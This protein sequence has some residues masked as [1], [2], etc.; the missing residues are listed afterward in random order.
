M[1]PQEKIDAI[2]AYYAENFSRKDPTII[3][4]Y[5]PN[6]QFEIYTDMKGLV[7]GGG[8]KNITA[9]Q[10]ALEI[11]GFVKIEE[12]S[13]LQTLDIQKI[14]TIRQATRLHSAY[15]NKSADDEDRGFLFQTKDR[16]LLLP[17]S[18]MD[19]IGT[20]LGD[21]TKES[22]SLLQ[23]VKEKYYY[24]PNNTQKINN[25]IASIEKRID[26]AVSEVTEEAIFLNQQDFIY[27]KVYSKTAEFNERFNPDELAKIKK[28]EVEIQQDLRENR[29]YPYK[30]KEFDAQGAF[31]PSSGV[32]DIK[33]KLSEFRRLR[34][35]LETSKNEFDQFKQPVTDILVSNQV[36]FQTESNTPRE[37]YDTFKAHFFQSENALETVIFAQKMQQ[38]MAHLGQTEITITMGR[39]DHKN[40]KCRIVSN[41]FR[42]DDIG[43]LL[44]EFKKI[45]PDS[46]DLQIKSD[47]RGNYSFE[48]VSKLSSIEGPFKANFTAAEL[49]QRL[50]SEYE[51]FAG[52]AEEVSES[53]S[54]PRDQY[55]DY[56]T[57][58]QETR[59]YNTSSQSI[60]DVDA[61]LHTYG[62][63]FDDKPLEDVAAYFSIFKGIL[64]SINRRKT[65][66]LS[67]Q[68]ISLMNQVTG[69]LEEIEN[70][71][72]YD[73]VRHYIASHPDIKS[74]MRELIINMQTLYPDL[75]S[76]IKNS[77]PAVDDLY[78]E[79][80][81]F[82]GTRE[83]TARYKGRE[84]SEKYFVDEKSNLRK[85]QRGFN[86]S[87]YHYTL[88]EE[89]IDQL[90]IAN[91]LNP[92]EIMA[93]DHFPELVEL[94][95][96]TH[97]SAANGV[98]IEER[99][100]FLKEGSPQIRA[101][102]VTLTLTMQDDTSIFWGERE[103][104]KDFS[105]FYTGFDAYIEK[106]EQELGATIEITGR[107]GY[108]AQGH[109]QSGGLYRDGG[110]LR[111]AKSKHVEGKKI[112]EIE[113]RV[114]K[115]GLNIDKTPDTNAEIAYS[116][117]NAEAPILEAIGAKIE[118]QEQEEKALE[119]ARRLLEDE[120]ALLPSDYESY[121]TTPAGNEELNTLIKKLATRGVDSQT[122]QQIIDEREATAARIAEFKAK[123]R[124]SSRVM[125]AEFQSD[126]V[127]VITP[128]GDVREADHQSYKHQSFE[129]LGTDKVVVTAS[130][131]GRRA[132]Q[133]YFT[134]DY[135]PDGV[136]PDSPQIRKVL[137]LIS[138]LEEV[139]NFPYEANYN[140]IDPLIQNTI[141]NR[142]KT[143]NFSA[144][145]KHGGSDRYDTFVILPN[146]EMLECDVNAPT[147]GNQAVRY[148]KN[149]PEGALVVSWSRYK[150]NDMF[151]TN[152]I[153]EPFPDKITD[154]QKQTAKKLAKGIYDEYVNDTGY[155]SNF[156]DWTPAFGVD[157]PRVADEKYSEE[158]TYHPPE[159]PAANDVG[160]NLELDAAPLLSH[161]E[162]ETLHKNLQRFSQLPKEY[163]ALNG[164]YPADTPISELAKKIQK[165]EKKLGKK[166]YSDLTMEEMLAQTDDKQEENKP[167]YEKNQD[168]KD[169]NFGGLEKF[170]N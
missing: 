114:T 157:Q 77:T 133:G 169:L 64:S 78:L 162:L 115:P 49:N 132:S 39:E 104:T 67:P 23:E 66:P 144:S 56:Q 113:L 129:W 147:S 43:T 15:K 76:R 131:P 107:Y 143:F 159:P 149:L 35:L 31:L 123:A 27:N 83:R 24:H 42:H 58:I 18:V 1:E 84:F 5:K 100:L 122:A 46:I 128:D 60:Q 112:W 7:I 73:D 116:V 118:R 108:R 158:P 36:Q 117:A 110:V 161:E 12:T 6:G 141:E 34:T 22:A 55:K 139:Q 70:I 90:E 17:D 65:I 74:E 14:D 72:T 160:G 154:A 140:E 168:T 32:S 3:P 92:D 82:Q 13:K 19:D 54:L 86:E 119:I 121:L 44:N 38:V 93:L 130:Q 125:D 164:D 87:R 124:A 16:N 148:W 101:D 127:Y 98:K 138:K 52:K 47:L 63:G 28:L 85:Y 33:Q 9:M 91:I 10:K 45:V 99:E 145:R 50:P 26:S 94:A 95:M 151:Y 136:Q 53:M 109:H 80:P 20:I 142:E 41:A 166:G 11:E 75:V 135:V 51:A 25:L 40:N 137:E 29:I 163:H 150:H 97:Q 156:Q 48:A 120:H 155:S 69:Q 37:L 8:G 106:L 59:T 126:Y 146:G 57:N 81:L 21:F 79:E 2:K 68:Q 89:S 167:S 170:M 102:G 4:F 153:Q 96:E 61:M 165:L 30:G 71:A 103:S 152:G 62:I 105:S 134:V 88:Y 111:H